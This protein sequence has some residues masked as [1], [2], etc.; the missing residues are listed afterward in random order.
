[1]GARKADPRK[2]FRANGLERSH[3]LQAF[4]GAPAVEKQRRDYQ[5]VYFLIVSDKVQN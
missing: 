3:F 2:N 1:V 4:E 5:K